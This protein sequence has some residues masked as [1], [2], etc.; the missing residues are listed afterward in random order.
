MSGFERAD[1]NLLHLGAEGLSS[2][3]RVHPQ[4]PKQLLSKT[5]VMIGKLEC[6]CW[7]DCVKTA[8]ILE[9]PRAEE[10]GTEPSICETHLGKCLGD[11]R[12]SRPGEAVQPENTLVSLVCQPTFDLGKNI[13]PRP[14]QASLPVPGTVSS[15]CCAAQTVEECEVGRFLFIGHYPRTNGRSSSGT[16]NEPTILVVDV[17]LQRRL[18]RG[19]IRAGATTLRTNLVIHH[20]VADIFGQAAKF[21]HILSAIQEPGHLASLPQRYEVSENIVQFPRK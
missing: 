8:P 13:L 4:D 12:L 15:F 17:L 19:L 2:N 20:G 7:E 3:I 11:G 6:N 9:V 5:W 1:D 14:P 21:I 18:A 16:H 10:T